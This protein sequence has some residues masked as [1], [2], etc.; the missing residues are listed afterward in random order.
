MKKALIGTAIATG[1]MLST[2]MAKAESGYIGMDYQMYT[3]SAS[4]IQ[5][6]EP[7][8]IVLKLGGNVNEFVQLEGRFGRS[9][10]DDN[11]SGT[12]LK[13]DEIIGFYV[14]GGMPLM[15]MVFPYAILGYSKV[16]LEFF[17]EPSQTESDM[18]YG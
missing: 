9:V 3:L 17:G 15:D 1:I 16:D 13:I 10:A 7:Q 8:S 11:A 6:L 2:Q 12:A 4:G 14:K 5:D 18:S